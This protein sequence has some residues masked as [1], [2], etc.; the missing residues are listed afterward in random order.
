MNTLP[1]QAPATGSEKSAR[2]RDPPEPQGREQAFQ[3]SP[4]RVSGHKNE[5]VMAL[6]HYDSAVSN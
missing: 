5:A 1:I 2:E 3:L 4:S 6:S